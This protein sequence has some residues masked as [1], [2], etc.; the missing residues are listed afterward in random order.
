VLHLLKGEHASKKMAYDTQLDWINKIFTGADVMSLK[1]THAGRSQGAKHAELNGTPEGQIRR[2]GRWNNDALTNC[3]LTHLPRKFM[4]SMAGFT[5]S[6]QGNFYLPRAKVLPSRSLE[7]AV[8]PWVDEWLAWFDSNAE[9]GSE[10]DGEGEG[11]GE[12]EADRQDLA[13]QGFLR[14]LQQ[15]RILLLQDSVVMRREFPAHPIWADP[16]FARDDYLAFAKGVEL[17]LLDVEKPEEIQIRKA[18]PEIAERLSMLHQ[19][20]AR[21]INEWGAGT[22]QRLDGIQLNFADLPEGRISITLHAAPRR[23]TEV[24]GPPTPASTVARSFHSALASFSPTAAS[25]PP[26][27]SLQQP[28]PQQQQQQ[29]LPPQQ[30]LPPPQLAPPPP[31]AR[32]FPRD[33]NR[34]AAVEGVDGRLGGRP[35]RAR[36]GG[37]V[38]AALAPQAQRTGDVRAAEGHYR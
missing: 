37:H 23:T 21:D 34:S 7:Q 9:A 19:S 4:Q 15:L 1:K 18:L 16:I 17:S 12:A 24:S 22:R 26:L 3:Y 30:P 28:P 13:A 31:Y 11:E 5:P 8:W 38:W 25:S 29:L 20:L 10:D 33:L 27:L 14:L 36:P 2:A 35:V 32:A 6:V